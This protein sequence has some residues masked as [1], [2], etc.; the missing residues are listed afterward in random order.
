MQTVLR[1]VDR[2]SQAAGLFAVLLV[3]GIVVL[4]I[5]EVLCR[6]FFNLSLSFAWEYSAYFLGMAIFLG[7]AFTLRT[8]GQVRVAFLTTSR[9]PR[10]ARTSEFFATV[11]GVGVTCYLAYA[12]VLFAWQAYTAGSTSFTVVAV[13][14]VYPTSG[15][16]VGA[17][18]LALQMIVRLIRLLIGDPPDDQDAMRSYSV[19]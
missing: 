11:F 2:V 13:P 15:L 3:V 7:A 6:T 19:E 12:L 14:L 16:A 1:T 10:L 4:I 5:A 17:V 18:L 9:N 8:G